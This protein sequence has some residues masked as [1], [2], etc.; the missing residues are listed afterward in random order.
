LRI[1]VI[2]P[3]HNESA[4]IGGA[5]A[6]LMES[7]V[8][9]IVV[10]DG[11]SSDD[12]VRIALE[13]GATVVSTAP[14]RDMQMNEGAARATGDALL[15]LHADTR[16][17][18]GFEA[19]V[20]STLG[21]DGVLAGAFTLGIDSPRTSMRIVEWLTGLRC[22]LFSLPYGDQ[23]IFMRR[24]VFTKYGGWPELQIMED[25]ELMR[26]LGKEGRVMIV[27]ERV[28]TSPRRW[29]RLGVLRTAVINQLVIMGYYLGFSPEI[30][31]QF[32]DRDRGVK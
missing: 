18:E 7:D 32:Y 9:E 22:R 30:L 1:S 2:I 14:G 19:V 31:K 16:L 27:P 21:Q 25:F 13:S 3:T 6:S 17:P 26:R 28:L 4:V 5:V 23:A 20:R 11:G 24:D 29:E 12:T 8:L 15:F 10:S